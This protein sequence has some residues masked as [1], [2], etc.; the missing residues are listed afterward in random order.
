MLDPCKYSDCNSKIGEKCILSS[1]QG[2][3][4]SGVDDDEDRIPVCTCDYS[5]TEKIDPV[6]AS[7]GHQYDNE[8]RMQKHMCLKNITLFVTYNG[9]CNGCVCVTC[10]FIAL[11]LTCCTDRS[12]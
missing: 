5:C 11:T 8:C 4:H 3:G 1:P 10:A 9:Q 12:M 6:C 7:D 2:S